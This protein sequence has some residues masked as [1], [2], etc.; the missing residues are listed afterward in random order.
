KAVGTSKPWKR[1]GSEDD[2]GEDSAPSETTQPA[3]AASAAT[4]AASGGDGSAEG[5]DE[6]GGAA[7][8]PVSPDGLDY[9]A[10]NNN[11]KGYL[12]QDGQLYLRNK[13]FFDEMP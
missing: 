10:S 11:V 1:K 4:A 5:G 7:A 13:S 9:A 2:D 6:A 8:A 12:A 3:E